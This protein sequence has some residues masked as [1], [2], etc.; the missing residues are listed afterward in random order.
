MTDFNLRVKR[1][2][3]DAV[4]ENFVTICGRNESKCSEELDQFNDEKSRESLSVPLSDAV[5]QERVIG[6]LQKLINNYIF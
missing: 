1:H 3:L 2:V 6:D 5:I 4:I